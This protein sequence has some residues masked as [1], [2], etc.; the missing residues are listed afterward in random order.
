MD[1]RQLRECLIGAA[2][3]V[4]P[5]PSSLA[6]CTI[7]KVAELPVRIVGLRALMPVK[8]NGIDSQLVVDSGAF[9]STL[10]PASAAALNLK[11]RPTA[12][13]PYI[14]GVNGSADVSLA[15]VQDFVLDNIPMKKN[16]DFLVGGTEAGGGAA[17]LLGENVLGILDT[18]YD[19][20]NGMIRLLKP[21]GCGDQ[22]LAYWAFSARLPI[23]MTKIEYTGRYSWH[24]VG[25]AE[26]NGHRIRVL[27]D[28]GAATSVLTLAAAK[29]AGVTP[30]SP[31]V[32]PGG[33]GYGIG[34]GTYPTWL[35][36]FASLRL[37]GEETRN[38]RIR[39]GDLNLGDEDML[40]GMD[41]FL[42]HHIYVANS[43][44]RLYFTYNGGPVFN[45]SALKPAASPAPQSQQQPHAETSPL[46][47]SAAELAAR[48]RALI[49]RRDFEHAVAD[50]TQ[51]VQLDSSQS[52]Y[53][54]QRA[55]AYVG[56]REMQP[57]MNDLDQALKLKPDFV[58]ALLLRARMEVLRKDTARARADL[59]AADRGLPNESDLRFALANLYQAAEA[60][61]QS[62]HQL[63][64][65]IAAHPVDA[66]LSVAL[67]NRCWRLG[68]R[69]RELERAEA[70]CKRALRL[71]PNQA[72]TLDSLGWVE[73]RLGK[74]ARA[75]Q[76]FNSALQKQP[77][78]PSSLYG[79]AVVETRLGKSAAGQ[80]DMDAARALAPRIA[81]QMRPWGVSP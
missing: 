15:T 17:G 31:G 46:P 23:E 56:A 6:S 32:V 69:N 39:F 54:Y 28:T 62:L 65:W 12:L 5:L 78:L 22:P 50:L 51:A 41:F 19:L 42:S 59:D 27:F 71:A 45:L 79:R 1:W 57:A 55:L 64:L 14:E 49:G 13:L 25:T 47:L 67:N 72:D 76:A 16:W 70:D 20:S 26:L 66:R 4:L 68:L 11:L 34:R 52:D 18:E 48:G 81:E 35:G 8:F 7:G 2:A 61:E 40:L 3:L 75:M 73:L 36:P 58:D 29:R 77:Q 33:T 21:S 63:D 60:P 38:T 44:H 43:Q 53:F 30:Q 24:I 37:G 10:S 9:Y 80:A 74:L